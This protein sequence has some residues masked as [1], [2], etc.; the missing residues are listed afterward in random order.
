[1]IQ[2]G[3]IGNLKFEAYTDI[4]KDYKAPLWS[5]GNFA[6]VNRGW[7]RVEMFYAA[8][9][10]LL[11]CDETRKKKFAGGVYH[12]IVNGRRA[13]LLYGD[14]E[15]NKLLQPMVLSPLQNSYFEKY[16]PLNG[17]LSVETENRFK[18]D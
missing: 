14:Y 7:C 17:N 18:N 16:H 9:I 5:E 6:Y 8:N 12:Q 13:H 3:K 4:Y 15:H 2:L 1:M 10:P 11:P